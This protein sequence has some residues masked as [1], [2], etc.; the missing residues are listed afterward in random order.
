MPDLRLEQHYRPDSAAANGSLLFRI[1]HLGGAPVTP[2]RFCYG[3]QMVA[4]RGAE[5][6]GGRLVRSLATHVEIAAEAVTLAEGDTWEVELRGLSHAPVNRSQGAMAAWLEAG[7]DSLP[8]PVG[9]LQPPGDRPA[10]A[11]K[12]WPAGDLALPVCLLPWPADLSL[13]GFGPAPRLHAGSPA[14]HRPMAQVAALH[15]RLFPTAPAPFGLAPSPGSIAVTAG[16]AGLPAGGFRLDFGAEITLAHADAD[17]L[18]HGLIA[19]AQMAHAARSDGRFRF[20]AS[21]HVADHPRHGWRGMHLD[22]ARNFVPADRVMR[23]IDLMAWH[24]LNRFHWHLTDDEGW[25]VPIPGLPQLVEIGARRGRGQPIPPQY[26]DGPG[27]H[28]GHYTAGQIREVVAHALALGI[29][30][31]PEIDLPGH[32]TALLA[33]LPELRDPAE[34]ADSYRSVQGFPNNAINPG[35]DATWPVLETILDGICALFPFEIVHLG[36]DEVDGASWEQSPAARALV[37][38]EGLAPGAAALQSH[39]MRRLQA[40]L[41]DRGRRLAGWDECADGGGVDSDALLFAWRTREKTAAL[42][43]AGY[44]VICTPGQ[45]Y[46][47]DM[48]ERGGW[49]AFGTVWAGVSPPEACYRYEATE[50]LPTDAGQLG[51]VQ[52]GMW[53]EYVTGPDIFNAIAFPRLS[54]IAEAAWTPAGAKDWARFAAL[55]HLMPRL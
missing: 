26:G 27:G 39:I 30:T 54:A 55:S 34:P 45:A 20:P 25:R 15:R 31:M 24:R 18:R 3:C 46:Y 6:I 49:D 12:D 35:V 33:A 36:G 8:I 53:T 13:D 50:G 41:R 44:E 29:E 11:P 5:V 43:Q 2:D 17:G 52:A 1:H 32:S 22:V 23:V 14:L 42:M 10:G 47:L 51:G 38:R 28:D 37:A 21:G 7:E 4:A 48:A 40:M 16:A 9:D 19:L